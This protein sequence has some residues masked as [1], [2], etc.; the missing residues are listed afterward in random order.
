LDAHRSQLQSNVHDPILSPTLVGHLDSDAE[1]FV[2]A[3]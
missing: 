3:S 2:V 1:H